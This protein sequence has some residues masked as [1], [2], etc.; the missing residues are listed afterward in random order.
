MERAVSYNA[1]IQ[2]FLL[3]E[4]IDALGPS[5]TLYKDGD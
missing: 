4:K 3:K 5:T 1:F 2:F